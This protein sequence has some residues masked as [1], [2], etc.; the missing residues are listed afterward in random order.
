VPREFNLQKQMLASA[1][2]RAKKKNI[3]FNLELS[4]IKIPQFCPLLGMELQR[5][6]NGECR[7][8]S[9]SLDRKTPELG[10]VKGNVWVISQKAN[11]MKNNGTI[12]EF[13]KISKALSSVNNKTYKI[14]MRLNAQLYG[15]IDA[16]GKNKSKT[17]RDILNNFFSNESHS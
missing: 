14:V 8:T 12:D 13:L 2:S 6:K 1:K 10:Y 7:D 17:I 16:L 15:K 4:D 9:P 5:N 3:P 11:M